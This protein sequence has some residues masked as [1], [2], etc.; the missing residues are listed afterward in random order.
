M[1]TTEGRINN[2]DEVYIW[3][4]NEVTKNGLVAPAGP[5]KAHKADDFDTYQCPTHGARRYS[6]GEVR[7][8]ER[9]ETCIYVCTACGRVADPTP[10]EGVAD[11]GQR[12]QSI[13]NDLTRPSL[14]WTRWRAFQRI[15][16]I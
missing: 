9:D 7:Q 4:L 12:D 5:P 16:S 6:H 11:G 10:I 14:M 1:G 2:D 15:S 3:C 13:C 8:A